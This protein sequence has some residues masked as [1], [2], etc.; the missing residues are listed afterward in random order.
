MKNPL[1]R[2]YSSEESVGPLLNED[3]RGQSVEDIFALEGR[4]LYDKKVM[5]LNR[6]IDSMGM[7]KYQ[8][9]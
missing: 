6:E 5:I 3:D 7:G 1:R 9:W 8:W 4:S 2:I